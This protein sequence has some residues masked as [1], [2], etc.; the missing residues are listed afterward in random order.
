MFG[1]H[2]VEIRGL[3]EIGRYQNKFKHVRRS[4]AEH[5]WAVA[6]TAK[7]LAIWEKE[8][9]NHPIDVGKTVIMALDHDIIEAYTGDIITTTKNISPELKEALNQAEKIVLEDQ[10]LPN[11]PKSWRRRTRSEFQELEQRESLESKIVKAADQIDTIMECLEDIRLGSTAPYED[12]LKNT[13]QALFRMQLDSVFYFMRYAF[14]DIGVY[15]YLDEEQRTYLEN[16]DFSPYFE[17]YK[18]AE[19]LEV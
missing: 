10:V 3:M 16:R 18:D 6:Q 1:S 2:L 17:Q 9:F 8:K 5:S 12:I 4:V 7:G 19:A 14:Q 11:L 15:R 13:V